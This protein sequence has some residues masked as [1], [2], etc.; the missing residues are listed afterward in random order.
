MKYIIG[1]NKKRQQTKYNTN[2]ENFLNLHELVMV[3]HCYLV[4]VLLWPLM[5]NKANV[6]LGVVK[7]VYQVTR[8]PI[9]N[10]LVM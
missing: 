1:I 6:S 2:F 9:L 3:V 5:Y 10:M 7:L 8:L 4:K